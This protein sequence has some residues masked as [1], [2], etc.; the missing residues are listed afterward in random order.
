MIIANKNDIITIEVNEGHI[1]VGLD[2]HAIVAE[3]WMHTDSNNLSDDEDSVRVQ[4]D[5]RRY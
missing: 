5:F 4:D 3:I 1:L 2:N